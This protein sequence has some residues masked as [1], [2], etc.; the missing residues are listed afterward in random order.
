MESIL[1]VDDDVVLCTMLRDYFQR[2]GLQL[3][4][5]HDGLDGLQAALAGGF[6]LVILDVMLPGLDGFELLRR[7]RSRSHM[8]IV[9]LTARDEEDAVVFGLENGADDY[10]PKPC[11]PRELLLRIRTILRRRRGPEIGADFIDPSS[12]RSRCGF[13]FNH[14]ARSAK[15]RGISLSLTSVEYALLDALLDHPGTVLAREH[16]AERVFNRDYHPLDRG[17]DMLVSRLRRKLDVDDN[18]GAFIKTIR[19]AGY[20]FALPDE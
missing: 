6:D 5:C 1:I 15:Y 18:P 3:A 16:L 19:S 4:M 12:R 20:A 10:V 2:H 8:S 9:I 17:L 14:T 11:S 7:L 13:V